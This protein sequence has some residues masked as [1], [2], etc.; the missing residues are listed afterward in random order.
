MCSK[1]PQGY[2]ERVAEAIADTGLSKCELARRIGMSR[3]NFYS[4]GAMSTI[5]IVKFCGYTGVSADWLL[6]LSSVKKR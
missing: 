4:D 1:F 6:G 3:K 5:M 2:H